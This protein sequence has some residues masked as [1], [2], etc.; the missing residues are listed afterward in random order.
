VEIKF[1]FVF[2][3][4]KYTSDQFYNMFAC[5]Q[6]GSILRS[7]ADGVVCQVDNS[8]QGI[9]LFKEGVKMQENKMPVNLDEITT[10][11]GIKIVDAIAKLNER[12]EDKAYKEIPMGKFKLTDIS[13]AYLIEKLTEVFGPY[14]LGWM[15][16][17][18]KDD[19][20]CTVSEPWQAT[21]IGLE[22]YYTL[23]WGGETHKIG[24]VVSTGGARNSK[25][26]E[27]ALKGAITNAIGTA[28]HRIGWQ[29]DV[30]KG[31]RTELGDFESEAKQVST[32]AISFLEAASMHFNLNKEKELA[33]SSS[34]FA[35]VIQ[36]N[37][38][39][40][41][42]ENMLASDLDKAVGDDAAKATKHSLEE[43]RKMAKS[44]WKITQDMFAKSA[45]D[46]TL[47]EFCSLWT[48]FV[49]IANGEKEESVV[50][51]YQKMT[52]KK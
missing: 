40:S 14:G 45:K 42:D 6:C 47:G 46:I 11:T 2:E 48:T 3:G 16:H 10:L 44:E 12:L 29:L 19:I 41:L 37:M 52:G 5:A 4:K 25:N 30:Y 43:L 28:A 50:N 9:K 39:R 13:P 26:V 35:P 8:H 34:D 33:V 23:V 18:D 27:Y 7:V 32:Q 22:F 49:R 51:Q 24:P 21:V 36:F 1:P 17:F 15:Y 20:N 31:L 38:V